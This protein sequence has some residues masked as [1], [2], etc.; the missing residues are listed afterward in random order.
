MGLRWVHYIWISYFWRLTFSL[1]LNLIYLFSS[2][3]LSPTLLHFSKLLR[4]MLVYV[5]VRRCGHNP[6]C[7]IPH[8]IPHS[9]AKFFNAV[10]SYELHYPVKVLL[11][12]VVVVLP[13]ELE[14][15]LK[16]FMLCSELVNRAHKTLCKALQVINFLGI[17]L[18]DLYWKRFLIGKVPLIE[19]FLAADQSEDL[20]DL[21]SCIIHFLAPKQ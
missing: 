15:A 8:R 17:F 3:F 19:L 18:S 5:R 2:L 10:C 12:R 14:L 11:T 4:D 13:A 20:F 6:G 7:G 16:D 21:N 1:R 9:H